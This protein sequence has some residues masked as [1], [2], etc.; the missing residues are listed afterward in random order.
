MAD[1]KERVHKGDVGTVHRYLAKDEDGNIL[2]IGT[3]LTLE[4]QFESP[5]GVVVTRTCTL[6]TD[7]SDGL[8]EYKVVQA[9]VDNDEIQHDDG[10]WRTSGFL[11]ITAPVYWKGETEVKTFPVYKGLRP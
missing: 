11:E 8:F 6:S 10:E 4:C 2:D 5:E 3:A 7:G 1:V 9:D